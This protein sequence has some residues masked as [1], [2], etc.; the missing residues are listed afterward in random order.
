MTGLIIIDGIA[1]SGKSTTGQRLYRALHLNGYSAEFY[2]EFCRPHP[3]LGVE[4]DSISD[5]IERS[6]TAWRGFIHRLSERNII[7]VVDGALFQCGVGELLEL[8][9]DDRTVLDYVQG[10]AELVIP[11]GAIMIHLYQRDIEAALRR[12]F[13]QR[14]EAWRRR[15][16]AAFSDTAYGRNRSLDGFDLYLDFNRSLRRLSD[17]MFDAFDMRKLAIENADLRWDAYFGQIRRFLGLQE[18]NDPFDP[19]DFTGE[20]IETGKN[21]RCRIR[22]AD[23]ILLVEGLFR[24]VKAL[25]PKEDDTVFV[26]TWPDELTF[27]RDSSNRVTAFCSTGPWDRL[28]DATWTRVGSS[29]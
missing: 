24:I 19:N 22:I 3:V 21:R 27:T 1:G 8:D 23:G 12:V 10:I 15:V 29:E 14:P 17:D 7:A 9:A 28:G 5:W 26:Q 20:Y 13:D 4:A 2:H 6:M 16:L 11:V 18:V 25:L